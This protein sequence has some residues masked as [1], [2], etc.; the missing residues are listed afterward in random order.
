MP[1]QA[2][3]PLKL[4]LDKH[5]KNLNPDESAY[6]L[7]HERNREG[8]GGTTTPLTGNYQ[9]GA[10]DQPAGENY[11]IGVCQSDELN[12]SYDFVCNSNVGLNYIKRLSDRNGLEIVYNDT[13]LNLSA[14]PRHAITPS[15]CKLRLDT[16]YDKTDGVSCRNRHGKMLLWT[17]SIYD[18]GCLDVEA[19]ILTDSFRT[20]FFNINPDPASLLKLC[21]PDPCTILQGE[22]VPRNASDG[23]ANKIL[24]IGFKFIYR[25]IYYDERKS[26]WSTPSTAYYQNKDGCFDSEES[27]PRCIKLRIPIGNPQVDRIEVAFNKGDRSTDG[28]TDIWLSYEII[29]KYKKYNTT[30]QYWYERDLSEVVTGNGF[31]TEDWSFDYNFCNDKNCN[32]IE[33]PRTFNP[34]PRQPQGLFTINEAEA[35]FN[36]IQGNCKVDQFQIEKFNIAVNCDTSDCV[37]ELVEVTVNAV[38]NI[39]SSNALDYVYRKGG[40]FGDAQDD[41]NDVAYFGGGGAV[42]GDPLP[43]SIAGAFG[44]TFNKARNFVAYIEGTSYFVEMKQYRAK[45]FFVDNQEYGI[46]AGFEPVAGQVE[47]VPAA[48]NTEIVFQANQLSVG[49]FFNQQAT[50]KVPKGTRGVI[51]I[52]SHEAPLNNGDTSTYVIGT[53][54]LNQLETLFTGT[55]NIASIYTRYEYEIP[56]DTCD[57][58][59]VQLNDAFV[60]NSAAMFDSYIFGYEGYIKDS[61]GNPVEGLIIRDNPSEPVLAITDHNGYYQFFLDK[62]SGDNPAISIEIYGEL[63]CGSFGLLQTISFGGAIDQMTQ[64]DITLTNTSYNIFYEEARVHILDCN[65]NPVAG[66]RVAITGSKYKVTDS[67]GIATFKLRNYN[68]RDRVVRAYVMDSNGCFN[69]DCSGDCGVC[70]PQTELTALYDCFVTT[71]SIDIYPTTNLNA[72]KISEQERGLKLGGRFPFGFVVKWDCGKISAVNELPYIDIP[73]SQVLGHG[74][75]CSLSYDATGMVLPQGATCLEIVRGEN[76]NPYELQW[77]VDKIE[78][79]GNNKIKLSFQSLNDYNVLY[80]GKTNTHYQ[81]LEGDRVEFISDNNGIPISY[82]DHGILNYLTISPFHDTDLSGVTTADAN[83]FNQILIEDDGKLDFLEAGGIIEFQRSKECTVEPIYYSIGVSIP[84]NDNGE[85]SIPVGTFSS[86]D[87]FQV[88]RV[89]NNGALITF[90]H[91]APSDFWGNHLSDIGKVYFANKYE[92]ER[93]YGKNITIASSTQINYFGDIVKTV[94]GIGGD[95]IAISIKDGKIIQI[96]GETDNS[97]AQAA[98]DLLRMGNDGI[99]R[100]SP[101]DAVISDGEP[102]LSGEYGCRYDDIGSIY[103]GDGFTNWY[104]LRYYS[105]VNSNYQT[106]KS[107]DD[108]KVRTYFRKIG[109]Q[110]SSLNKTTTDPLN[111]MR[112]VTGFNYQTNAVQFTVK[113]LRNSG[114]NNEIKPFVLQN[115]TI[116]YDNESEDFLTFASPTPEAYSHLTLN[117]GFGCAMITYLNGV[118]YIHPV[119]PANYNEFYGVA[120]D[121]VVAVTLNQFKEKIKIPISFELQSDM[122][123]YV[124]A[125]ETSDPNFSSEIPPKRIAHHQKKWNASFLMNKNSRKGLYEGEAARDYYITVTFKRDNTDALKYGSIDNVKRV[126]FDVLS[127]ILFNF[128]IVEPSGFTVGQSQ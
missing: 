119:I 103:F 39:N 19:S 2:N 112:F 14:E 49:Y 77:V 82:L 40:V 116:L 30:Q 10:L 86:F 48:N 96:I 47:N 27:L 1:T 88:R 108:A 60:I 100:A 35:W 3:I 21:V 16:V 114:I 45:N 6:L 89:I 4:N 33:T 63:D 93:R 31:S 46:L 37:R 94:E 110:L 53:V 25:W 22:F 127:M 12:E 105:Y 54:P 57:G 109:V 64:Y 123:Y 5:Q 15:R 9:F 65:S 59:D 75:F 125:V 128:Q 41:I 126:K 107:V 79:V 87:T 117:D 28:N 111:K 80:G 95:I 102:K 113:A 7:N 68:T 121:R 74:G 104:D 24:D 66:I 26:E 99:V 67:E 8:Y 118:P 58:N 81:W 72:T 55:S 85:L 91:H 36:Y 52:R 32:P 73:K 17:D 29:E 42:A 20:E 122:M 101:P 69:F 11:T 120:V 38:I 61:N 62:L 92:N 76:I 50:F 97:L 115:S 13:Y 43:L 124:V 18:I 106:T 84:I 44:Q 83:Y 51:R 78:R 70:Y 34:M 71:P 23:L 90:E 98:D 56:F